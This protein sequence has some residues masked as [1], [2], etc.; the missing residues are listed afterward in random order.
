[1]QR[2]TALMYS[3]GNRI[4]QYGKSTK[5]SNT[6]LFLFSNKMLVIRAGTHKMIVVKKKVKT[7][8]RLL[9]RSSLIWVCTVFLDFFLHSFDILTR[10]PLSFIINESREK[11]L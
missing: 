2:V 6:F 3:L 7:L 11:D 4:E 9:L 5:L 1:M 10:L 8:I